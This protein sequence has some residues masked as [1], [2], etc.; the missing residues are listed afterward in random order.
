M[1]I[2]AAKAAGFEEDSMAGECPHSR[3]RP[4]WLE[5]LRVTC[6]DIAI[7]MRISDFGSGR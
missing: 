5:N 2:L 6:H 1:R 3:H 7:D 4:G